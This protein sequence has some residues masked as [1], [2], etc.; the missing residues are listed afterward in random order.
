[1]LNFQVLEVIL[2]RI[3]KVI[4][5]GDNNAPNAIVLV[6]KIAYSKSNLI[7]SLSHLHNPNSQAI[8]LQ[9]IDDVHR[10]GN[11]EIKITVEAPA[12]IA[13]LGPGFDVLAMAID[14][15]KD[16]VEL[17][18]KPGSGK[19]SIKVEGIKVPEGKGNVAYGV[20]EEAI[21][22][23]QL[24]NMDFNTRIIKG[25]PP[26]SGLGSSGATAAAT[27]YAI[28]VAAGLNLSTRELVRLSGAGEAVVAGMPHYDNVSASILGGI[29]LIDPADL[30]TYRIQPRI[31]FWVAVVSPNIPKGPKKTFIAR[32]VLPR[33]VDLPLIIKQSAGLAKLV[34]AL[35]VGDLETFGTA[36]SADYIVEPHRAKLIPKYWNLKRIA[37]ENGALGFNIAGAGPSVFSIHRSE[38]EAKEVGELMLNYLKRSGIDASLYVTKV[39]EHGVRI[40][41]C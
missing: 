11:K 23:Y 34:Y 10:A 14:K 26:A 22:K 33:K 38:S 35:H 39:S 18:V 25:V 27:A 32:A 5:A 24:R 31:K 6:S 7:N 19:I 16:I 37:L 29:V 13:N 28:S 40:I 30:N 4:I 3:P 15:F 8:N 2:K 21:E 9:T 17:A 1:M 36:I 20:I 12:S 41:R